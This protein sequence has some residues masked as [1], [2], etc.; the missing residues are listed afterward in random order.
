MLKEFMPDG[1]L[2]CF[3][4]LDPLPTWLH[5]LIDKQITHKKVIFGLW[6]SYFLKFSPRIHLIQM[7]KLMNFLDN[8]L[9]I[10]KE[11]FLKKT[12]VFLQET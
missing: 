6:V 3:I 1:N 9:F 4:M 7:S 10:L 5:S 8:Q 2:K 11:S 12:F